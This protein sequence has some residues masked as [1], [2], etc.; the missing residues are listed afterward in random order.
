MVILKRSK[1][2]SCSSQSISCALAGEMFDDYKEA[3]RHYYG[4]FIRSAAL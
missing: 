3:L 4:E 1:S 2:D